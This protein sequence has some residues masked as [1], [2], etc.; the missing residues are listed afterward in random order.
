MIGYKWVFTVK[1][2]ADR[3][4]KRYKAKLVAKEYTQTYGVYYQETFA[5]IA[6]MNTIKILL[7]YTANLDWDLHQFDVKNVFLHRDLEEEV[8]IKFYVNSK[9]KEHK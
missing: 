6:K 9:M 3:S 2:K 8:Y 4:I 7:S 1:H 5:R